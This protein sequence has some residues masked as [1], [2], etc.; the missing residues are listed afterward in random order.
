MDF[1]FAVGAADF[2]QSSHDFSIDFVNEFGA[3][4]LPEVN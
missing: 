4:S 2:S 1:F 3:D